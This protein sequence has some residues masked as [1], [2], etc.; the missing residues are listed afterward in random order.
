MPRADYAE[1]YQVNAGFRERRRACGIDKCEINCGDSAILEQMGG[2]VS[3]HHLPSWKF[4]LT[5]VR[6][7]QEKEPQSVPISMT[8][9]RLIDSLDQSLTNLSLRVGP[10]RNY[11]ISFLFHGLFAG[12]DELAS[13]TVDPQ[14]AII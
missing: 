2:L 14:Q 11:L 7:V 4:H 10:E 6:D 9:N 12:A 3:V 5:A 1:H 8:V 13:G